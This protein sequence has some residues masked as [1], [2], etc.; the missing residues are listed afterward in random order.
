M[1][2]KRIELGNGKYMLD[3]YDT[4]KVGIIQDSCCATNLKI[5]GLE[6]IKV[7]YKAGGGGYLGANDKIEELK[8]FFEYAYSSESLRN[9]LKRRGITVLKNQLGNTMTL[10][11][12]ER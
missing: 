4:V 2:Y 1:E 9:Y 6:A 5:I 7:E 3:V 12:F 10:Q 8:L 11:L